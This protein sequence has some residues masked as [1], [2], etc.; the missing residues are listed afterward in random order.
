MAAQTWP[1]GL[2]D[3]VLQDGYSEQPPDL[4]VRT[5]MDVGT[6]KM[7]RRA[8]AAPTP[9]DCRIELTES[10]LETLETFYDT[11]LVA[12]TLRFDW[13][14]PR[15]QDNAEIRFRERPTYTPL[16]GKNYI[17]NLQIE[18]MP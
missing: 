16:G 17:A 15:T 3:Y 14:H 9:I 6:P 11:T 10:E 8:T 7:R 18:V 13:V 4:R 12:G 2:P 5:Q 1:S